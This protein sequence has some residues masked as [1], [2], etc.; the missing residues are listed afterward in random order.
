MAVP[1]Y[2]TVLI[3]GSVGTGKT[4]TAEALGA[5]LERRDIPGATIDVDW[6]RRAWPAPSDDP[7]QTTLALDNLQTIAANFRRAG[8]Q[9]LIVAAV[10]ETPDEL[11]RTAIALGSNQLLHVRLTAASDTV[12][13]R[14]TVRHSDDAAALEWHAQR[15]PELARILDQAG[16]TNDLRIDTTHKPANEAAQQILTRLVM[17]GRG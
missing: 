14:L 1:A 15:H 16:F 6:L 4:T 10:I 5:E 2:D 9:V 3:N 7:F 12:L 8:A 17:A 11:R 13:S